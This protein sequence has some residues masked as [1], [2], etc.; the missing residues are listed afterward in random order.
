MLYYIQYYFV[1]CK[2][3]SCGVSVSLLIAKIKFD[4]VDFLQIVVYFLPRI[5]GWMFVCLP[6]IGNFAKSKT[7]IYTLVGL[8]FGILFIVSPDLAPGQTDL[9]FISICSSILFILGIFFHLVSILNYLTPSSLKANNPKLASA[10]ESDTI[11]A[12]VK[13]KRAASYKVQNMIRNAIEITQSTEGADNVM[14]TYF[15]QAL[16]GFSKATETTEKS[17]GFVWAIKNMWNGKIF[18][19]EGLWLSAKTRANSLTMIIISFFILWVGITLTDATVK[20]L[21]KE[22]IQAGVEI[23]INNTLNVVGETIIS[24]TES[25]GDV[26]ASASAVGAALSSF[27]I[28]NAQTSSVDCSAFSDTFAGMDTSEILSSLSCEGTS[29]SLFETDLI[30][31]LNGLGDDST[32]GVLSSGQLQVLQAVGFDI[33]NLMTV[34]K[35]TLFAAISNAVNKLYPSNFNLM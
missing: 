14:D 27:L 29:C 6:N 34:M 20:N 31:V 1:D 32:S 24:F 10:L 9:A 11:K 8:L 16:L 17:G 5:L 25:G 18:T 23:Y 3:S 15:G 28:E 2:S 4:K 12:E 7:P 22:N 35:G 13:M 19:Q 30:C 33:N 26:N 21:G